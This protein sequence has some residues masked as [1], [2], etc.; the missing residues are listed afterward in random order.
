M[1]ERHN[2]SI[3]HA[4]PSRDP[5]GDYGLVSFDFDRTPP[6]TDAGNV[7]LYAAGNAV[8]GNG[9]NTGAH[10][11]TTSVELKPASST[12]KP[13]IT[14][15]NGVVNAASFLAGIMQNTWVTITGANLAATTRTWTT[16]ELAS[17]KLPT[18]LDGLSDTINGKAAYVEYVSPTQLNVVAPADDSV[19]PVNVV[20]T[21]NGQSSDPVT[22][23][24]QSFSPAFFAYDGKYFAAT[25]ANNS[26]LGK[27]GLFSCAPD[28]TS[29]AKP[30]E[31]IVLYGTRSGPPMGPPPRGN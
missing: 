12:P 4:H 25:H 26:L 15:T 7:R 20:V 3:H 10:I 23:T 5:T 22:A 29:P 30:G 19:G 18:S 11:Y 27:E 2:G 21:V 6:S 28:L 1:R 24:L 14:S 13:T 16:D 31:T 8:N 17:G 9:A